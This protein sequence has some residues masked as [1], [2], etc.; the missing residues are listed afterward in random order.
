MDEGGVW[1]TEAANI[2]VVAERYF[3]TLFFTSPSKHYRWGGRVSGC[4][5]HRRAEPKFAS[6]FCGWGIT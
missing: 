2:V 5:S 4:S 1:R 3:T 6:T